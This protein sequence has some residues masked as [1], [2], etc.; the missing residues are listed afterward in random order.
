S[1]LAQAPA[2]LD[3]RVRRT[4]DWLHT[5]RAG[6]TSDAVSAVITLAD[7]RYPKALLAIE[8]PPLLLYVQG[9]RRWLTGQAGVPH[10]AEVASAMAQRPADGAP[11]ARADVV[12]AT[13]VEPLGLDR[14]VAIVGSRNPTPQGADHARQF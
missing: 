11:S 4:W 1:A 12:S 2:E 9:A 7:P 3:A 8:D 14:C 6:E 10:T 13:R 5:P